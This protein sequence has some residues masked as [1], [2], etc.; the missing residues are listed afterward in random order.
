MQPSDHFSI[1]QSE[2]QLRR[3][4]SNY[5]A[6]QQASL[7]AILVVDENRNLVSFNRRFQEFFLLPEKRADAQ[8][9]EPLL[10][11]VADQVQNKISFVQTIQSLYDHPEKVHRGEVEMKDGRI[12]DLYSFPI[13][14]EQDEHFGRILCFHDDTERRRSAAQIQQQ[15]HQ[16][17]LYRLELEAKKL[18]LEKA[19]RMLQESS[20]QLHN[21][22]AA[23]GLT[24]L[25]N[26][27]MF[28]ERFGE[29]FSRCLRYHTPLS[30][31]LLDVDHFKQYNHEFGHLAGDQVL[32]QLAGLLT[33]GAR[34]CDL[35]ARYGGGEFVIL[36]PETAAD[37]AAYAAER[38]RHLIESAAWPHRPITASFGVAT[39]TP[40]LMDASALV[41]QADAALYRSKQRG[42]NCV[43]HSGVFTADFFARS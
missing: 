26:H 38:L 37:S 11:T 5:R 16:L 14:S 22:A 2:T 36:L 20:E 25:Y 12:L 41:G 32:V 8:N 15:T 6:E 42:R 40:A 28:Q 3:L 33:T 10:S 27:R 18:E 23:D 31:I 1:L 4:T 21:Q 39:V 24:G 34:S 7:D 29:E 17:H 35:A 30:V 43:T 9:A 13:T 19:S